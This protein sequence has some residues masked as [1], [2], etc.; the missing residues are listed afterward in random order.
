MHILI[1][2]PKE[3][4][5]RLAAR[6][7]KLGFETSLEPLVTIAYEN[8]DASAIEGAAGLIATSRNGLRALAASPALAQATTLPIFVTG[9]GTAAIAR[10]V[11][12]Q[13]VFEGAG[14]GADLVPIL[15]ARSRTMPG[16]LLHL[17][18]D[19]IAFDLAGALARKSVNV[20][21]LIVYR[22]TVAT[23]L[24]DAARSALSQGKIDT[25]VLMSPR[26]ATAWTNVIS[27]L[28]PPAALGE[29]MHACLSDAV[30]DALHAD[31]PHVGSTIADRPNLD[32]MVVLLKRLADRPEA[33]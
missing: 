18:G 9:P 2:R 27:A 8:I 20:R 23:T 12:F 22:A 24:S 19:V 16:H 11:G 28:S 5:E 29:L 4:A 33:G 26:T 25:V 32:A 21:R 14:T 3:D 10:Q 13:D 6:L 15:Y 17:S 1:T 7:Q 31:L 30:A